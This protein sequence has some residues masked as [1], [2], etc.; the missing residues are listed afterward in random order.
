[1]WQE[2]YLLWQKKF[3]IFTKGIFPVKGRIFLV[4]GNLF[5]D[6]GVEKNISCHRIF[7][8]WRKE[9]FLSQEKNSCHRKKFPV[10]GRTKNTLSSVNCSLDCV[11]LTSL[12][13]GYNFAL[14]IVWMMT[15]F[16]PVVSGEIIYWK[17]RF[18]RN[19]KFYPTLLTSLLL[20]LSNMKITDPCL[21]IIQI[22]GQ[23]NL[24]F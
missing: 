8:P 9:Y 3:N 15:Q 17:I 16:F 24:A 2:E 19:F 22:C 21:G 5:P 13:I 4:T 11:F 14:I 6:T 20:V 7:F 1:M 10:T 23:H 18:P 12:V